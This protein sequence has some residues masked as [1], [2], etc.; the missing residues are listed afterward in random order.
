MSTGY[1]YPLKIHVTGVTRVTNLAKRPYSLD[2]AA[3][4]RLRNNRYTA[5]DAALMCNA[6]IPPSSLQ[7]GVRR[8]WSSSDSRWFHLRHKGRGIERDTTPEMLAHG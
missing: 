8:V 4:T 5:C 6:S 7:A 2:F 3:V 1:H